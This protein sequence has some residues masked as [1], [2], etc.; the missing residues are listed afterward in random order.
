MAY[1]NPTPALGLAPAVLPLTGGNTTL[2]V[3]ASSMIGLGVV[4]L[5]VSAL[6]T[7]KKS[8]TEIN[9]TEAN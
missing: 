1:G 5:V 4:V 7:R 8:L 3:I 6:I 2:L 9:L